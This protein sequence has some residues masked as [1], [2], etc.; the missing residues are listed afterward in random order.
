MLITFLG[1]ISSGSSKGQGPL[2]SILFVLVGSWVLVGVW[3]QYLKT[4]LKNEIPLAKIIGI[5]AIALFFII[6]GVWGLIR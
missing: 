4:R 1:P 5:S 6:D 2:F 3:K